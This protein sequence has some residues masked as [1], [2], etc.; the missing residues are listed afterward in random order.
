MNLWPGREV[1]TDS[2]FDAALCSRMR[3][4]A[5][6][7]SFDGYGADFFNATTNLEKQEK[8]ASTAFEKWTYSFG[9]KSRLPDSAA[10]LILDGRTNIATEINTSN[11][12]TKYEL[13]LE[14]KCRTP[15][16]TNKQDEDL[17][18]VIDFYKLWRLRSCTTFVVETLFRYELSGPC[19]GDI[20]RS[21]S[22]SV[23]GNRPDLG[24]ELVLS[25][26]KFD[27]IRDPSPLGGYEM[28]GS[29]WDSGLDLVVGEEHK[30]RERNVVMQIDQLRVERMLSALGWFGIYATT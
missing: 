21:A 25:R 15:L 12:L 22:W 14:A 19:E 27:P 7:A 13:F 3:T 24:N 2:A 5:W 11:A 20:Q 8:V 16:F 17:R 4:E 18:N 6:L 30:Q 23:I 10:I 28:F 1:V 26:R 9:G 29:R